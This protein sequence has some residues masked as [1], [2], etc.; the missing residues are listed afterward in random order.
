M[1][2]SCQSLCQGKV[3]GGGSLFRSKEGERSAAHPFS[4]R[5]A[6]SGSAK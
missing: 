3:N 6:A 1:E 5:K 4:N 2:E